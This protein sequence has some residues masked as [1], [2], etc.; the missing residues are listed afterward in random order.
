M[1][2]RILYT[3]LQFAAFLGLLDVGGNWDVINFSLQIRAMQNHTRAFNPIPVIKTTLGAHYILI[4]DGLL[5][6]GVL[7]LLILLMEALRK[8]LRPWAGYTV[9][10]FALAVVVA[11]ALKMGLVPA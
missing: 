9:L 4:A 2:K 7:L 10:A 6:A 11:Y 5:F 3:L 1:I 8:R